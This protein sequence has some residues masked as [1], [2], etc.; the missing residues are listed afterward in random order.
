MCAK[1]DQIHKDRYRGVDFRVLPLVKLQGE[2][3]FKNWAIY[4]MQL[5]EQIENDYHANI[6]QF[7]NW[8][9]KNKTISSRD[10]INKSYVCFHILSI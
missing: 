1:G 10:N 2:M 7:V 4:F 6:S 8:Q 5:L 3:V 9:R